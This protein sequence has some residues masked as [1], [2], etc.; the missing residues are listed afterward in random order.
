[1]D[2]APPD[3]R[4]PSVA[5]LGVA[6]ATDPG[7]RYGSEPA[8]GDG[9]A[10]AMEQLFASLTTEPAPIQTVLAGFNGE[11]F[12]AKEWG[13]ARLRHTDRF[14]PASRIDHPADCFGDAGAALGALL[15]ALGHAALIR[16]NRNGPA[17]VFA[18]SDREQRACALLDL[19]A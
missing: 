7:H 9:L 16:G 19:V 4:P 15:L 13:V 14:A 18:S 2:S 1:M 5:V 6:T 17:L 10:A 11:N 8:R 3:E 12:Q